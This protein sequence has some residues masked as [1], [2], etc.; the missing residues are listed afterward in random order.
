MIPRGLSQAR[1]VCIS[2]YLL[3]YYFNVRMHILQ[4]LGT[5]HEIF[6]EDSPLIA[7]CVSIDVALLICPPIGRLIYTLE[8]VFSSINSR[9]NGTFGQRP[10]F[11]N[12]KVFTKTISSRQSRSRSILI[13]Y[14]IRDV[15]SGHRFL[16]GVKG[17]FKTSRCVRDKSNSC[18]KSYVG[19]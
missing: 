6:V 19:S 16:S 11:K 10:I 13:F 17:Y 15:L 2:G 1:Y 4:H 7:T 18:F 9:S 12:V 3:L 5:I 14:S 8:V